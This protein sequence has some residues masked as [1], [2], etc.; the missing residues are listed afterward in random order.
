[1]KKILLLLT[2]II[3]TGQTFSQNIEDKPIIYVGGYV[4]YLLNFHNADFNRLRGYPNCC[5]QFT[6]GSGSSPAV[7]ILLEYPLNPQWRAGLRFGIAG[8]SGDLQREQ[9]IGNTEIVRA[10]GFDNNEI[11]DALSN[12]E[13]NSNI[14][15]IG[16]EPFVNY[17]PIDNLNV[18]AGFRI[19]IMN[20]STFDQSERLITPTNVVF[21]ETGTRARNE[22]RNQ[23]IPETNTL[24]FHPF[25]GIGYDIKIFK[26]ASFTPEAKFYVPLSNISEENWSVN[27]LYFGASLKFPI[28]PSK[29]VKTIKKIEYQRDTVINQ[30][31]GLKDKELKLLTSREELKSKQVDDATIVET[32]TIFES[33]QLNIPRDAKFNESLVITGLNRDGTRQADPSIIIEEVETEERFPLL[34]YVFFREGDSQLDKTSMNLLTKSNIDKF[35]P[36]KLDWE[37][38]KIYSNLL[39]IIG[40]RLSKSKSSITLTGTNNNLPKELGVPNLSKNRAEAVKNYLVDVWGIAPGRISIQSRNLPAKP[41]N[42]D[43][44]DGREENQRVE[45]SS[46]DIA[47][48]AP[49]DMKDIVRTANPPIIEIRPDLWSEV[50][51]DK[52]E[53]NVSQKGQLL[54]N[55][56]GVGNGN[57][58]SWDIE[59]EP[60]PSLEEPILVKL[61][62]QDKSGNKR[63]IEKNLKIS[64]LTI[65]KKR[66]ELKDD[67]R[68][69]RFSLILF[70]YDK[71]ELTEQQKKLLQDIKSKIQ[72]NSKVII[73]GFADRTGEEAYNKE[74]SARR[75]AEVQKILKVSD[76]QLV[77]QN[78]GSSE[79][80]YDNSSPEGRSYCRT[81]KVSIETPVK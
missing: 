54:R 15:I 19:G 34:P 72:P 55:Y 33:Y 52:W 81:V 66:F 7:G 42:N 24:Q 27:Q 63:T 61:D 80:L 68:I 67:K 3:F 48:I 49:L 59:D 44:S 6:D 79:L 47:I 56:S 45:I 21:T 1:M 30:I 60:I 50:G 32:K 38:L 13:I 53:I 4:G 20:N 23:E 16:I 62:Y 11:A 12:Y 58:N 9:K 46:S 25:I 75:N 22:A 31:A 37:T 17:Y 71:S 43:R 10:D 51:I 28:M 76:S 41:A 39:N 70:D 26:N 14:Q 77:M 18:N 69:E 36:D 64:Q 57:N 8:L 65:K 73:S 29:E 74:L 5:P 35:N 78:V 40:H 2:F